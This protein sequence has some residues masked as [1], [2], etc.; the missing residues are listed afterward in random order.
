MHFCSL[1][2]KEWRR[3]PNI[4][5]DPLML[6]GIFQCLRCLTIGLTTAARVR[7]CTGGRFKARAEALGLIFRC[8][9]NRRSAVERRPANFQW[10]REMEILSLQIIGVLTPSCPS[11]CVGRRA[12]HRS[13]CCLYVAFLINTYFSHLG[14]KELCD[15]LIRKCC[16]LQMHL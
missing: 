15:S 2:Q 10:N 14:C 12:S 4:H 3:H 9:L 6:D 8:R 5:P 13:L 11:L 1:I 16:R 7:V